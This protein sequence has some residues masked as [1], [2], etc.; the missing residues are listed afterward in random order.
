M[1]LAFGASVGGASSIDVETGPAF[2]SGADGQINLAPGS[3]IRTT[4]F[5]NVFTFSGMPDILGGTVDGGAGGSVT[6]NS[7]GAVTQPASS[8]I[9]AADLLGNALSYDLLGAGNQI[10]QIG[11]NFAETL[12]AST[13]NI[14]LV[15]SIPLTVG[16]ALTAPAA[17][18][19][20]RPAA[21]SP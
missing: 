15:D 3:V 2:G 14:T 19:R 5:G 20:S 10:A 12:T 13:G 9:I 17:A 16:G 18:S 6:L 4:A 1:S 21:P 7:S 11:T 8:A